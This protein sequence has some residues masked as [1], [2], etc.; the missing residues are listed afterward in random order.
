MDQLA[1]EDGVFYTKEGI[2]FTG[3]LPPAALAMRKALF[4]DFGLLPCQ[5]SEA[6]SYSM[7]MVVRYALGLSATGG[8]VLALVND[9]LSGCIALATIRHLKNAGADA[10]VV[11]LDEKK[12]FGPELQLQLRILERLGIK[13]QSW[14]SCEELLPSCH[15]VICGLFDFESAPSKEMGKVISLLNECHL[16]V[17]TIEAPIG[18]DLNTGKVG[19]TPLYASSTLSLGAPYAALKI[20]HDLVGRHYLCDISIPS[21]LYEKEGM[22]LSPLFADQPVVQI[23][24]QKPEDRPKL[25]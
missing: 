24:M 17:H 8:K 7:A 3:V 18:V 9:S 19:P 15:N 25:E 5:V 23:F 13:P 20:A 11:I 6:A 16:P 1:L 2:A 4:S 22:D 10:R 12:T 14:A 21:S